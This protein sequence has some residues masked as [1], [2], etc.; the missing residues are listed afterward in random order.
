M[1]KG[2]CPGHD[3]EDRSRNQGPGS[4][5]FSPSLPDVARASPLLVEVTRFLSGAALRV[6]SRFCATPS[7]ATQSDSSRGEW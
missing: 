1:P 3:Q 7:G 5:T 4:L 6:A 2:S